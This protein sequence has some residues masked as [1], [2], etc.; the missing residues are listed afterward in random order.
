MAIHRI[1]LA[2][3]W[4]LQSGA[5]VDRDSWTTVNLPFRLTD[6]HSSGAS[7]RLK[8]CFHSPTG[9]DDQT[10]I[11]VVATVDMASVFVRLNGLPLKKASTANIT[12]KP[13]EQILVHE[14]TGLLRPFNELEIELP[15]SDKAVGC[16]LLGAELQIG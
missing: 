3:P 8:R 4:Q 9:I 10:P 15:C 1:R 11:A 7:V 2:G 13:P 14:L 12:D 6:S 5:S 16:G